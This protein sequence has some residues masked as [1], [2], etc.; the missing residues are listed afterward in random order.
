MKKKKL[1]IDYSVLM[2]YLEINFRFQHKGKV[3]N[4]IFLIN[5]YVIKISEKIILKIS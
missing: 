3:E 1:E 5:N 4:N 2:A